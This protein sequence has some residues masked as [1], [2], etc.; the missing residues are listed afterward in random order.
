MSNRREY[1]QQNSQQSFKYGNKIVDY[2]LIRSKR[3][4]TYDLTVNRGEIIIRAPFDKSLSDIENILLDK[5]KWISS[6]QKDFNKGRLEILKPIY[7][8]NSTLPYLGVNYELQVI[9][10]NNINHNTFE[11]KDNK[12]IAQIKENGLEQT[13]TVRQLYLHWL[14]EMA[15]KKFQD[16]VDKNSK[17]VGVNPTRLVIKNLKN[18]WGSVSKD[19]SI[20]L[21]V[22]LVK[23]PEDIIEYIIIHELCHFKIKGHSYQFWDYLKQYVPDYPRKVKWL[24][25]N[26]DNLS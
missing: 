17:T 18:R 3:R 23:A 9:Y 26:S 16:K 20:N 4:K 7:Q 24:E 10:S 14:N 21:N 19:N 6:K 22:N 1:N 8:N 2:T 13:D 12:F 15:V 5:V 25:T 11:Y